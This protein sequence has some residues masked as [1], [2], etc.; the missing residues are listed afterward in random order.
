MVDLNL[1]EVF[2]FRDK[3]NKVF[4]FLAYRLSSKLILIFFKLFQKRKIV[5]QSQYFE[6]QKKTNL[7]QENPSGIYHWS[8]PKA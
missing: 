2:N 5:K 1:G 8:N 7:I 3:I 6:I 4:R